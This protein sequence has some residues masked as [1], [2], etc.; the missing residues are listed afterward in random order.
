MR[1]RSIFI[2]TIILTAFTC[3][4]TD[5]L[6]GGSTDIKAHNL[7]VIISPGTKSLRVIDEITLSADGGASMDLS[8]LEARRV[9]VDVSGGVF[10]A[11]LATESVGGKASGGAD[12]MI[13]GDPPIID[14]NHGPDATVGRG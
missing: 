9:V 4:G 7:D 8:L 13:F 3:I 2:V 14:V 1:N 11:V 6:A 5:S 12:V 10:V